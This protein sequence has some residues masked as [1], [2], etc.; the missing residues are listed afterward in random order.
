MRVFRSAMCHRRANSISGFGPG[1]CIGC[2][3]DARI[4]PS[5]FLPTL[6]AYPAWIRYQYAAAFSADWAI[7]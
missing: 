2:P 3:Y 6:L 5:F 1:R 4:V 7:F